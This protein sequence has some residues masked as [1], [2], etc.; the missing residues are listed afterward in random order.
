MTLRQYLRPL[1]PEMLL[2]LY[3]AYR[4]H[5]RRT[6]IREH[7]VREYGR[8]AE[9]ILPQRS[10]QT[11]F[12]DH[13]DAMVQIP[14]ANIVRD[15]EMEMPLLE[16]I[17][18]AGVV[19]VTK[20]HRIFEF[21]TYLGDATRM[22]VQHSP[23]EARIFTLDLDP[24]TRD[25]YLRQVGYNFAF[26]FQPG[27]Y[28]INTPEAQHIVQLYLGLAPF[29]YSPYY[30]TM[31]LVLVDADHSYRFVKADTEI[32]F[33]LIKPGGVIVWD[34]YTWHDHHPECVGVTRCLN[35]LAD[36]LPIY[37]IAQTRFGIYIDQ[38]SK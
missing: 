34:D 24:A 18:L 37:R 29:D 32:A 10:L 15:D 7:L 3:R 5:H 33:K 38:P 19:S 13:A 35:E 4:A 26:S 25:E 2:R 20:P 27:E 6:H 23:P 30:G 17:S 21:G 1:I 28:F 8:Y 31:D 14:V 16:I 12:A 22:M 36:T 9:Y 11:L